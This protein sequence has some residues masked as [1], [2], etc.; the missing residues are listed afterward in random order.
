MRSRLLQSDRVIDTLNST[1]LALKHLPL[2]IS[3]DRH[4]T[5]TCPCATSLDEKIAKI[6]LLLR[7]ERE[8]AVVAALANAGSGVEGI[9]GGGHG[10]L[11]RDAS[12]LILL[13]QAVLSNHSIN[14]WL[15]PQLYPWLHLLNLE[16]NLTEL[17]L[18]EILVVIPALRVLLPPLSECQMVLR[19]H[20]APRTYIFLK[21]SL[22]DSRLTS[23]LL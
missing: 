20:A 15:L 10:D 9:V 12:R 5:R 23:P 11:W 17:L 18:Q 21:H 6:Q 14:A 22:A 3:I 7:I 4:T 19:A 13:I 16:I 1:Q 2:K 8:L